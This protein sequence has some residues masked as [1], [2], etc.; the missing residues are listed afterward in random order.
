[1]IMININSSIAS[2]YK[3]YLKLNKN[4]IFN[5]DYKIFRLKNL[6]SLLVPL[7]SI[8]ENRRTTSI[9]CTGVTRKS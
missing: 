8:C 5:I 3:L 7:R 4:F 1:M 9:S 6:N 2:Q